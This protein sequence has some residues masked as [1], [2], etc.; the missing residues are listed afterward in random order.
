MERFLLDFKK[1]G[2]LCLHL[3]ATSHINVRVDAHF[4]DDCIPCFLC[5]GFIIP[6]LFQ[7]MLELDV[8]VT[9]HQ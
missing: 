2:L 5:N 6:Q 1:G 3:L 7:L 8:C 4:F 9:M